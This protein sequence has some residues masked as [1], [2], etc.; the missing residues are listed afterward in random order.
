MGGWPAAATASRWCAATERS[1]GQSGSR[2]WRATAPV[3]RRPGL[4][5]KGTHGSAGEVHKQPAACACA[6]AARAHR[7]GHCSTIPLFHCSAIPRNIQ[8]WY[9]WRGSPS[10]QPG[11][12]LT[13]P[14]ARR[15]PFLAARGPP[16]HTTRHDTTQHH[17][18]HRH[19]RHHPPLRARS[20]PAP[21]PHARTRQEPASQR[22]CRPR[23][24]PRTMQPL[25]RH[26]CTPTPT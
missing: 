8:S 14:A 10:P 22:Q 20:P 1:A 25:R 5:A 3:T 21:P 16:S 4:Q 12:S 9:F 6:G 18:T 2:F 24:S 13:S 26:C 19:H 15:S 11:G 7:Q 23:L 17:P